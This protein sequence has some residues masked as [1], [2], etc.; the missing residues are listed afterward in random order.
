MV[1]STDRAIIFI[2]LVLC[3]PICLQAQTTAQKV[4]NGSI[5]GKVTIKGKP[6][7][8][9]L[10]VA[11]EARDGS[12]LLMRVRTDQTGSYRFANLA[13]GTYAIA[14]VTPALAPANQSDSVVVADGEDVQDVNISLA[15]GGVITGKITDSEGEPVIGQRVGISPIQTQILSRYSNSLMP[16]YF[17]DNS[18]DDRG[19]YR[20]FG[21]PPGKY[22]VSVGESDYGRKN[23]REYFKQTFYPSVTDPA[24]ATIIEVTEGSVTNDVDIVMGRPMRTFTVAGRVVDE[25]GKPVSGIQFGV[26]QT[27]QHDKN[28]T[29]SSS[30]TAGYLNANGEFRLENVTPGTYTIYT[31]PSADSDVPAASVT[32]DVVDQDLDGLLIKTTK[33]GSLSG[34]VVLDNN[35]SAAAMLSNMRICATVKS[36]EATYASS[37]AGSAVGP[38][39]TFRIKGVRGG[40]AGIWLCSSDDQRRQFEI[41][42]VE[43]NGV[44]QSETIDVKAGEHVTGLRVTVKVRKLTGALRGQV[45]YENGELPP[46]SQLRLSLWPLDDNLQPKR[47]SS[48]PTPELD[49]RGRF[50]AEGLPAGA[51]NLTVY[52]YATESTSGRT[53]SLGEQVQ[54]VTVAEDAVTEVTLI[55]K[56]PA[57]PR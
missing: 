25:S 17:F 30:G 32:I 11:R 13:A 55:I 7:V 34:V 36:T 45:K 12:S 49:A 43:H 47:T 38:D 50:F 40:M 48:I 1:S 33:A 24:K 53:R 39:G 3:A 44:P 19:V 9:V 37:S 29:S 46:L 27:I 57:N 18:T 2:V 6:A 54:Q 42:R 21:L 31:S 51:Y 26:G 14:A 20:A 5:G 10:I 35:E 8:G 28:T 15:P 52:V 41:V 16:R 56:P 23:S 22:K 4:G